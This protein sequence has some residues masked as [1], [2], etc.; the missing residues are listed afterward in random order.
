M[1][2]YGY[3]FVG[4]VLGIALS[5][6]FYINREEKIEKEIELN[7]KIFSTKLLDSALDKAV[8]K[9]KQ[10]ISEKSRELSEDEKNEEIDKI[11]QIVHHEKDYVRQTCIKPDIVF[12]NINNHPVSTCGSSFVSA[13]RTCIGQTLKSLVSILS[14]RF[15]KCDRKEGI[16]FFYCTETTRQSHIT[17][18]SRIGFRKI[19]RGNPL[20]FIHLFNFFYTIFIGN[21]ISSSRKTGRFTGNMHIISLLC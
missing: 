6:Y 16:S 9:M 11:K 2:N 8:F 3:L 10:S 1:T 15:L 7:K 17:H 13:G 18:R 20:I 19:G 4:L 5:I 12:E 14:C 21:R